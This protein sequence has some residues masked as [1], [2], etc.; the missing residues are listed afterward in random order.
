M[1]LVVLH[2]VCYAIIIE[3]NTVPCRP[4]L[5]NVRFDTASFQEVASLPTTRQL[6]V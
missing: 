6:I 1:L 2:A 5:A 4:L 3:H